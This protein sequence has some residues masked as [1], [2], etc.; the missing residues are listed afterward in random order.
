MNLIFENTGVIDPMAITTFGATVKETENPIGFF[1]TGLKYA[2]AVL[3]RTGHAITIQAGDRVLRFTAVPTAIRGQSFNIVHLDG[4]PIGF[5]TELGKTWEVWMAYRELMCNTMDEAGHCYTA[6]N[7]SD[8][9]PDMTRIVVEGAGILEAHDNHD[10]YFF[11]GQS[12]RYRTDDVEVASGPSKGIYY[13]GVLIGD[14]PAGRQSLFRYNILK[15]LDLTED[16]TYRNGYQIHR[17]LVDAFISCPDDALVEDVALAADG[18]LEAGLWYSWATKAPEPVFMNVVGALME[19][20]PTDVAGEARDLFEKS[21]PEPVE[22]RE[23]EM[24]PTAAAALD[25]AIAFCE[26]VGYDVRRHPIR[27]VEKL[28]DR[29]QGMA[30]RKTVYV[31]R[32]AFARGVKVLAAVLIEEHLHLVHGYSDCTRAMQNHLLG[33]LVGMAERFAGEVL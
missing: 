4:S 25:R 28:G 21:V 29:V 7:V 20:R 3:L 13:R 30:N 2:I 17:I 18:T 16:R 10:R 9:D 32:E 15:K 23:W 6:D 31:A 24:D 12:I 1:G 26:S 22:P 11:N 33:E 19:D 8:P 27:V 14:V 5:T